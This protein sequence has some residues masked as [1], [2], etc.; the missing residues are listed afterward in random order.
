[1]TD[2]YPARETPIPGVTGKLVVDALSDRGRLVAWTP[3]VDS[4]VEHLIREARPGD[5]VLTLGAGD[6]GQLGAELLAHLAARR[7]GLPD[8]AIA[9]GADL[10]FANKVVGLIQ[11]NGRVAGV[12]VKNGRSEYELRAPLVVGADGR[13]LAKR[14]GDTRLSYYRQL[15]VPPERV[16][17]ATEALVGHA[18]GAARTFVELF[19]DGVW[20][21]FEAAGRPPE[22]WPEVREALE[23]LRP[24]AAESLLAMFQLVMTDRV[25]EAFGREMAR[26]D[27]LST[28][29]M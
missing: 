29:A 10:R 7:L 23:R 18:D 27:Q 16:L 28:S 11:E 20:Q 2:V 13:R 21:P 19:L 22:R 3:S 14:H 6:V 24:L 8:A 1:V 12:R 4:G 25:E 26:V 5:V 9:A 15:G 17:D